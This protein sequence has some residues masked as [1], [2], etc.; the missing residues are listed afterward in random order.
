MDKEKLIDRFVALFDGLKRGFGT[1]VINPSE[2]PAGTKRTGK[3]VT[4]I[5]PLTREQ[6]VFHLTKKDGIGL[7]V[8]PINEQDRC[9]FAAIDIDEYDIGYEEVLRRIVALKLPLVPVI[10]KSGGIH[11]YL[12]IVSGAPCELVRAKLKLMGNALG[13][14]GVE[15]FPKQIALQTDDDVGNWINLPYFGG[16]LKAT[17]IERVAYNLDTEWFEKLGTLEKFLDYAEAKRITAAQLESIQ[18]GTVAAVVK[19]PFTDGPPCLQKLA[20]VKVTEGGRNN[21]MFQFAVYA[22]LR[23]PDDWKSRLYE[24]NSKYFDPMLP[25]GELATVLKSV[26]RKEYHY[27]CNDEPMGSHCNKRT[28]LQRKYGLAA[29]TDNLHTRLD[30]G[31]IQV[32]YILDRDGKQTGEPPVFFWTINGIQMRLATDQMLNQALFGKVMFERLGVNP[33]KMRDDDWRSLLNDLR[34]KAEIIEA[35]FESGAVGQMIEHVIAFAAQA[36]RATNIA[37]IEFGSVY[38]SAVEKRA[39][40]A[41]NYLNKH[42]DTEKI[43]M[44]RVDVWANLRKYLDGQSEQKK[45]GGKTMRYWSIRLPDDFPYE[46]EAPAITETPSGNF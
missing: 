17:E 11:L 40:F 28:C 18:V 9:V 21:A 37:D 23:Y 41:W 38:L 26:E 31:P 12:F 19:M 22:K 24:F 30:F 13:F 4:H 34:A 27:K 6:Y 44:S 39:S 3:A 25:E 15:I 20:S 29:G 2:V 14:P 45:V 10:S 43:A 7:G 33:G 35:P 32:M 16:L 8:V 36:P 46:R 42:L 5:K 1:Y